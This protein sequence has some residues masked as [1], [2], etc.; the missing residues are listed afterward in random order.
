[1][2]INGTMGHQEAWKLIAI[3]NLLSKWL[4][5]IQVQL[6][7]KKRMSLP[8]LKIILKDECQQPETSLF[9]L[10]GRS[11]NKLNSTKKFLKAY[12]R[13][14]IK[15]CQNLVC[16]VIHKKLHEKTRNYIRSELYI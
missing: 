12:V 14:I 15:K 5:L 4:H 10:E 7:V 3:W 9:K 11:L 1:M 6:P 16:L 2:M 13:I 8:L